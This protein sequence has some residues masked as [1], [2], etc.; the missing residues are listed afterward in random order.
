M[1][2]PNKKFENNSKAHQNPSSKKNEE[3]TKK[4]IIG[5]YI[6][7]KEKLEIL[8]SLPENREKDVYKDQML[9]CKKIC[10][11]ITDGK[12]KKREAYY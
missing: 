2:I 5:H 4:V 9:K 10:S 1:T 12:Y 6:P 11:E 7:M 3:K 8:L